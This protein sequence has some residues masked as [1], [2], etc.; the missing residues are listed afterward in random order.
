ME[1]QLVSTRVAASRINLN[2][3]RPRS[4]LNILNSLQKSRHA[5]RATS[6]KVKL[7]RCAPCSSRIKAPKK[8]G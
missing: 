6:P 5:L 2:N 3:E 1:I 8:D 7:N 4:S